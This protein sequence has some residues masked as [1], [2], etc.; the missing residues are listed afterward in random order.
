MAQGQSLDNFAQ[1]QRGRQCNARQNSE[2]RRTSSASARRILV[3]GCGRK[4]EFHV[5]YPSQCGARMRKR[6]H[7]R[8]VKKQCSAPRAAKATLREIEEPARGIPQDGPRAT[9]MHN[10]GRPPLWNPGVAAPVALA[11]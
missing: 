10:R 11:F 4:R 1:K 8:P 3:S 6:V 9:C 7:E 2:T 5:T